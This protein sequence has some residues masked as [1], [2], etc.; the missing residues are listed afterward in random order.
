MFTHL[1]RQH[2]AVLH[3]EPH[4]S[5]STYNRTIF[6]KNITHRCQIISNFMFGLHETLINK[7][8]VLV[9]QISYVDRLV[10]KTVKPKKPKKSDNEEGIKAFLL[11]LGL[12]TIGYGIASLFVKPRC[13]HCN[14]Q[15]EKYAP[16]CA[17]CKWYLEWH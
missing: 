15:V 13:P 17:N 14:A 5:R 12:G 2:D 10:M 11:G 9:H 7:I 1:C 3:R 6:Y 8:C 16:Q 4:Y